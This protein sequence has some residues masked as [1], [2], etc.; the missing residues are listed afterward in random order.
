MTILG[1][2]GAAAMK[3]IRLGAI[4]AFRAI[5]AMIGAAIAAAAPFLLIAAA[6]GLVIAAVIW[7]I[8][9]FGSWRKI[10]NTV[11]GAV[12]GFIKTVVGGFKLLGPAIKDG[13]IVAL[14]A[15]L[16][17]FTSLVNGIIDALNFLIR[18]AQF[19][20]SSIQEIGA[21]KGIKIEN[22]VAGSAK[23]LADLF[24]D[25]ISEEIKVDRVGKIGGGVKKLFDKIKGFQDLP[26]FDPSILGTTSGTGKVEKKLDPKEVKK[27]QDALDDLL[28]SLSPARAAFAEVGEAL[29]I[30][31]EAMKQQIKFANEDDQILKEVLRNI[32]GVGNEQKELA[33]NINLVNAALEVQAI[34]ANETAI[35]LGK[36]DL[37]ATEAFDSALG[38]VFPLIA[39]NRTLRETQQVLTEQQDAMAKSG[40]DAAE[41]Q[42]RLL[43][44]AMGLP[45][46]LEQTN[47]Q[48][49]VLIRNQKLLGPSSD[50]L[51]SQLR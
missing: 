33:D 46:T 41:A 36:L 19:L 31:N 50:E 29:D 3:L 48:M 43:R 18:K 42:K 38:S 22:D 30:I 12:I 25:T 35:A 26:E 39:A 44:E 5:V 6:I 32:I 10:I 23:K 51:D 28:N 4:G 8:S 13:M 16:K 14:N 2:A 15:I 9:L 27:A 11:L 24:K 34:T 7:I 45:P 1:G 49:Q 17:A 21:F 40:I 47:E 37:E 20:G